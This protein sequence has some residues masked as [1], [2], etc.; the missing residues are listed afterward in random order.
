MPPLTTDEQKTVYALGLSI[1]NNISSLDLSPA[2]LDI[3]TRAMKDAAAKKPAEELAVWGPKISTLAQ[4]RSA[5]VSERQKAEGQAYL[6]KSA[7]E[8]GAVKTNSGL[9]YKEITPGS[10]TP[11]KSTDNVKVNYKGTLMDGTVFDSSYARNQPAEF[12]LNHVIACWTEG[13]QLMKP[14]GK[15][16]LVCPSSIAYGEHAP[17]GIPP[18]ATLT[19][20]VELLGVTPGAGAGTAG[21]APPPPPAQH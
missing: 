3:I 16:K 2:E 1:Y 8:Q 20:E 19:F 9:I 17:P 4:A 14:G 10:G 11:P 12:P 5:R 18:G 13:L 15:A 21:A 6:A 7:G